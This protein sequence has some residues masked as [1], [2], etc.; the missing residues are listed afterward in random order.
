MRF[1][2]KKIC[3]AFGKV[4]KRQIKN[5]L[6]TTEEVF[7]FNKY[8][9][10]FYLLQFLFIN[11]CCDAK[12][13]KVWEICANKFFIMYIS[14]ADLPLASST[15]MAVAVKVISSGLIQQIS[16]ILKHMKQ[17]PNMR[18]KEKKSVKTNYINGN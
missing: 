10:I 6:S 2:Y 17:R 15:A 3:A 13:S 18:Q 7:Y 14:S 12:V 11:C 9:N 5:F 1:S 8:Y 4:N 16:F